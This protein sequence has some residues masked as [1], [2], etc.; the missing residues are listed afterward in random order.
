[1]SD[2]LTQ[3]GVVGG[4]R[5]WL[6]DEA[7][8]LEHFGLVVE[9]LCTRLEAAGVPVARATSHIRVVHSERVGVTRLWRRAEGTIEQHF[10]F[11]A[12][13]DDMYRRS[14]VRVAHEGR[15]RFD[16]R[17]ADAVAANY[18]ITPDLRAAGITHYVI[19]PL[20][21]TGG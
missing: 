15:Q 19:Y 12:E 8:F 16:L 17:P 7:G 10:G 18:G 9:G 1:M 14:P 5:D 11:G 13:V 21:F 4:L 20:F 3:P 2:A 6:I